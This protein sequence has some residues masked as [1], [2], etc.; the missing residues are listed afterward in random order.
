VSGYQWQDDPDGNVMAA[1]GRTRRVWV[2]DINAQSVKALIKRPP[3]GFPQEIY[4]LGMERV[5]Y[6]LGFELGLPIPTVWLEEWQGH[7]CAVVRRIPNTRTLQMAA[8]APMLMSNVENRDTWPLGVAFDLWMAN[9]D[10]VP[11]NMLVEPL[12][13]GARAAVAT[14]CRTYLFDHGV[15]GLWFPSKFKANLTVGQVDQVHVGSGNMLPVVETNARRIM[16]SDYR[17]AFTTLTD[18]ERKRSGTP[19]RRSLRLSVA[20]SGICAPF[21]KQGREHEPAD[22]HRS[23]ELDLSGPLDDTDRPAG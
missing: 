6:C 16:P 15:T 1:P 18:S 12:P 3:P 20:T 4:S 9:N 17:E 22:P 19:G 23:A 13:E 8:A 7:R 10:R 11:R 5:A 2:R 21:R 14:S